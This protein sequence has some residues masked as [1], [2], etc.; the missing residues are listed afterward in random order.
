MAYPDADSEEEDEE[1]D[2]LVGADAHAGAREALTAAHNCLVAQKN[3]SSNLLPCFVNCAFVVPVQVVVEAEAGQALSSQS[4]N[5]LEPAGA[6]GSG[7][8]GMPEQE[9]GCA[10]GAGE[11]LKG[12]D[13]EPPDEACEQMTPQCSQ[14]PSECA[15]QSLGPILLTRCW[16]FCSHPSL[17]HL[18]RPRSIPR[19]RIR[20]WL[21]LATCPRT[22]TLTR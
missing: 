13:V 10:R 15:V 8:E 2:A 19:S 21:T 16:L 1:E 5:P 22:G 4:H 14:F 18:L 20:A 11:S 7:E 3:Q 9:E 17:D 6:A 12:L